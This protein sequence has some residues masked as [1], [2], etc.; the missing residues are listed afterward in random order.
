MN[1]DSFSLLAKRSVLTSLKWTFSYSLYAALVMLFC[2]AIGRGVTL[3]FHLPFESVTMYLMKSIFIDNYL[4]VYLF[5]AGLIGNVLAYSIQ[6]FSA[7]LGK[8]NSSS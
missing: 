4:P 3:F 7:V 6:H 5:I 2:E 8:N 1:F